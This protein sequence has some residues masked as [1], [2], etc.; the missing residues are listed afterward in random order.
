MREKKLWMMMC[1]CLGMAPLVVAC[2]DDDDDEERDAA[3][4]PDA[5]PVDAEVPTPT[6]DAGMDDTIADLAAANPDFS[7]LVAAADRVGLVS[8][9]ESPGPFT[10]F[11]PTDDAFAASGLTMSDI[12][13]LSDEELTQILSYHVVMGEGLEAAE[14]EPGGLDTAAGPSIVV[15]TNGGVTLNGGNAVEGGANVVAADVMASNGVVHVIDRVLLPPDVPRML[16]YAG[17][18]TLTAALTDA[19]LVSALEGEGPF[20]VFGP[21]DDA[22]A[23]LP[24]V[25]TGDA[26]TQVLTYHVVPAELTASD[27]AGLDPPQ[28]DTLAQNEWGNGL[29]L[30]FDATGDGVTVN[31]TTA[32][33]VANLQATNGV[34][35]VVDEVLVPLSVAGAAEALGLTELLSAVSLAAPLPGGT[36]IAETLAAGEGPFTVFAPTNDAFDAISDTVAGLTPD[37]VR[38]VLL[39][40]V[41]DPAEFNTPVLAA[42]L[43]APPGGDVPTLLGEVATIDT[44]VSPPTIEDQQIVRTDINVTNGVVHAVDGVLIPDAL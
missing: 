44:S 34:V 20:T 43:P 26:L 22:F 17:L 2:D 41:L 14:L 27:I 15:D 7:M 13:A 37:Q 10:V 18:D 3:V 6:P 21:T 23:A 9:L 12:D 29:T 11:A 39:F 28:A 1:V 8:V 5:G 42:D 19:D 4:L 16:T 25:P 24:E 40:H 31:G 38:D 33:T 32:V 36:T 35:H 30:L